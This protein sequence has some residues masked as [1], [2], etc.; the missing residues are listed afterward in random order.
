MILKLRIPRVSDSSGYRPAAKSARWRRMIPI[1]IRTGLLA[2][3]E[4]NAL[5][6]IAVSSSSWQ[7]CIVR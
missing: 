1:L 4:G 7:F 6:Q 2:R 5:I 3:A